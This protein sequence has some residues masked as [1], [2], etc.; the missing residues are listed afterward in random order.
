MTFLHY[1][2]FFMLYLIDYSIQTDI[3][4]NAK[5]VKR[6]KFCLQGSKTALAKKLVSK[7]S[8]MGS[9]EGDT[10]AFLVISNQSVKFPNHL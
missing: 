8:K 9:I 4:I 5:R 1:F 3:N 6:K 2:L 10:K 7:I